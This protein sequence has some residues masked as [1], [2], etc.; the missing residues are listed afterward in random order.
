MFAELGGVNATMQIV[1]PLVQSVR[2]LVGFLN[3][4]LGGIF[5]VYLIMAYINWKKSRDIIKLL[6]DIKLEIKHINVNLEKQKKK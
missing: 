4:I 5:G 6:R 1:D 3:I 2:F